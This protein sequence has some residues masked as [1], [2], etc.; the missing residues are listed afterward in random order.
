[1]GGRVG[2]GLGWRVGDCLPLDFTDFFTFTFLWSDRSEGR[3]GW[4][5][6]SLDLEYSI[7][8]L[9]EGFFGGCGYCCV[10]F[11]GFEYCCCF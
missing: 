11:V 8:N 6:S 1:M 5:G 2:V 3:E 10:A 4:I 7:G 9:I